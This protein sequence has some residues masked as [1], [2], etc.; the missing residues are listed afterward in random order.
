[1][2][3]QQVVELLTDAVR[4]LRFQGLEKAK[5]AVAEHL[6]SESKKRVFDLTDGVRAIRNISTI[7]GVAISTI[8]IW[9]NDWYAAGILT[10]DDGKYRQLFKLSEVGIKAVTDEQSPNKKRRNERSN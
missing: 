3:D 7:T 1:M 6:D 4:W 2:S 8:S 10:K 5:A 9:W